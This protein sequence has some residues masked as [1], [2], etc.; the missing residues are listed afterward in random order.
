MVI[1]VNNCCVENTL[2]FFQGHGTAWGQAVNSIN[3]GISYYSSQVD[4]V[5][6]C[7]MEMD[8][9]DPY[10]TAQWLNKLRD[11]S[12]CVPVSDSSV[13]GCFY[14]FGNLTVSISGTY[15]ADSETDTWV[16]CDVWYV[17]W[18]ALKNGKRFA[19]PLPEI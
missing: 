5:S 7:D 18:G 16:A 9:N 19:R 17:S 4:V 3:S 2:S 11:A 12:T 13:D 6:G 14:N 15:C 1:G 10:T 8:W